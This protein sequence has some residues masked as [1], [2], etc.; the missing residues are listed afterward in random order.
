MAAQES[1]VYFVQA[2]SVG[3]I[4]DYSAVCC[5]ISG[6]CGKSPDQKISKCKSTKIKYM[7]TLF[8]VTE[9]YIHSFWLNCST[10]EK[11]LQNKEFCK[12]IYINQHLSTYEYKS[13]ETDIS[14]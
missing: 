6:V 8:R 13:T 5:V 7:Y 1:Q 12:V 2:L 10:R 9:N 14:M 3:N 11:N 4:N